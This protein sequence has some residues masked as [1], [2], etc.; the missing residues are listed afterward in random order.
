MSLLKLVGKCHEVDITKLADKT[1]LADLLVFLFIACFTCYV[2]PHAL[3]FVRA[4]D[5]ITNVA[6]KFVQTR[7]NKMSKPDL[8]IANDYQI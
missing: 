8:N 1:K 7:S 2:S 5:I 3:K 6:P 4:H